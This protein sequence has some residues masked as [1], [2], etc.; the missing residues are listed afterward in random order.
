MVDE[1]G[2]HYFVAFHSPGPKWVEGT[3]YNQQPEF[4]KHVEYIS[5]LHDQG[6]IVVSGPFMEEPGGLAGK[7]ADGGMA[8]LKAVDLTEATKLGTDDPTVR[9][10]MLKVEMKTFWVPFHD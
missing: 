9:S 7:L 2:P 3:P 6:K 8:I 1:K 10:G 4:P 5:G